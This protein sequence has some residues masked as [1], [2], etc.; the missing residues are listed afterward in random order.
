MPSTFAWLSFICFS[1]TPSGLLHPALCHERL[2]DYSNDSVPKTTN[3]LQLMEGGRK[4]RAGC[5]PTNLP[6]IAFVPWSKVAAPLMV[7]WSTLPGSPSHSLCWCLWDL[8]WQQAI[9]AQTQVTA[10]SLSDLPPHWSPTLLLLRLP[11]SSL[12]HQFMDFT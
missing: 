3:W 4:I 2:S 8:G 9:C 11:G 7:A 10:L 1:R 12:K 5:L 6:P